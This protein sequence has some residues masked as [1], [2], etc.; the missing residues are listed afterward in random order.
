MIS[1]K[2]PTFVKTP[3]FGE[4]MEILSLNQ[5][6]LYETLPFLYHF[7]LKFLLFPLDVEMFGLS[8]FE[9]IPNGT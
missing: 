4:W 1:K 2:D 7:G 8:F 5:V 6:F 9:L 3:F